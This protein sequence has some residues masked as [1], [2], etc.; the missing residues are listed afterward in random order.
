MGM[1][2]LQDRVFRTGDNGHPSEIGTKH[3][4]YALSFREET[5]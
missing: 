1:T 5:E 4:L 2:V 3:A